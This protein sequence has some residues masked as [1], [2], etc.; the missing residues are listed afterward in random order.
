MT[1][2]VESYNNYNIIETVKKENLAEAFALHYTYTITPSHIL[3]IKILLIYIQ[4]VTE[5]FL[6]S[7][8]RFK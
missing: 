5:A 3:L 7:I 6:F 2:K 1:L 8:I 4:K